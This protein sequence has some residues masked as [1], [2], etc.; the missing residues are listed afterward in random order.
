[1]FGNRH[2]ADLAGLAS[3]GRGWRF[4]RRRRAE[5]AAA[6][7]A[8]DRLYRTIVG[9]ARNPQFYEDWEVPDTPDGRFDMIALHA[10]LVFRR[11]RGEPAAAV[12]A[13]ALFDRMFADFD[14]SLREMG[15]GDLRVGKQVKAMAKGL[16][17][18]IV[19]Y[20]DALDRGDQAALGDALRRNVYRHVGPAAASIERL[21]GYVRR[22]AGHLAE[23]D[24]AALIAGDVR[25]LPPSS[26]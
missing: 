9:Q 20:G 19:A 17:G 12:T 23:A 14:E 21:G 11:L 15:V 3:S 2:D 26:P 25:F 1:V 8:G 6:A 13:Q 5:A 18:R 16:Y 7:A 24:T 4:G 10:V 22:E